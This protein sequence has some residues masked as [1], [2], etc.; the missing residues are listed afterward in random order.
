MTS[1]VIADAK[2]QEL[3][4]SFDCEVQEDKLIIRAN[5]ENVTYQTEKAIDPDLDFEDLKD[6]LNN[7]QFKIVTKTAEILKLKIGGVLS[8]EFKNYE[9]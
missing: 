8:L 9:K 3:N 4:M 2:Y 1:S 7:K 6:L 5:V